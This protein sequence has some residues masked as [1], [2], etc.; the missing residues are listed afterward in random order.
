MKSLIIHQIKNLANSP[1]LLWLQQV[2]ANK[3]IH[4]DLIELK[5]ATR[6]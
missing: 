3:W 5:I 6:H 4:D 2:D 1:H